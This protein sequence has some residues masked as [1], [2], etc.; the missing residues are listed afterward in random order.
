MTT[1]LSKFNEQLLNFLGEMCKLFPEDKT[2]SHFYYSVDLLKKANP[3]EIMNQFKQ[4]IYP[5]KSQILSKDENFFITNNFS[6][7]I[8]SHHGISELTRIKHIWINGNL[9]P[10][11]KECIWNYFKVF[12]YLIDKE[13]PSK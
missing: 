2:L 6:D 13:Y 10:H 12:I 4:Y 3:R 1:T 8:K 5:F 11:D 9:T 7:S